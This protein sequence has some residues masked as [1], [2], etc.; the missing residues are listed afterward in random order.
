MWLDSGAYNLEVKS[1]G[2]S[3]AKRIYVLTGKTLKIDAELAS[4]PAEAKP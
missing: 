2:R 1:D 3:F 4:Q